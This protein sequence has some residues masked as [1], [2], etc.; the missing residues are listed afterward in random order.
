MGGSR[1]RVEFRQRD[2]IL[3]TVRRRH[4]GCS[5]ATKLKWRVWL[6]TAA[7]P[8]AGQALKFGS[9]RKVL[10]VFWEDIKWERSLEFIGLVIEPGAHSG[11][12]VRHRTEKAS[13]VFCNDAVKRTR[14]LFLAVGRDEMLAH[15]TWDGLSSREAGALPCLIQ[16]LF[17]IPRVPAT[18]AFRNNLHRERERCVCVCVGLSVGSVQQEKKTERPPGCSGT[19]SP[20]KRDSFFN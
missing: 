10:H 13:S 20:S 18:G 3:P 1:S 19:Q 6:Q 11:G 14:R 17:H 2:V 8:L 15:G 12:A 7:D 4:S 5:S 9:W 16:T